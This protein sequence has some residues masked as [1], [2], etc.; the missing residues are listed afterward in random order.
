MY[1][2]RNGLEDEPV[3]KDGKIVGFM[4]EDEFAAQIGAGI[5]T[6]RAWVSEGL[7]PGVK[8]GEKMYIPGTIC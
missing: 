6:V 7:L 5:H 4:S 2:L 1:I 3:V 8:I